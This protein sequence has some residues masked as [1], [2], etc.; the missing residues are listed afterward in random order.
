MSTPVL[1]TSAYYDFI[2][3]YQL[4]FNSFHVKNIINQFTFPLQVIHKD[5]C[6]VYTDSSNL[7]AVLQGGMQFYK[8]N[9]ITS[10]AIT[11]LQKHAIN[12]QVAYIKIKLAFYNADQIELYHCHYELILRRIKNN[13]LKIQCMINADEADKARHLF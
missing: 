11:P 2:D 3:Q 10:V 12:D 9:N 4:A 8:K 13:E 1:S 6:H 5:T 7:E